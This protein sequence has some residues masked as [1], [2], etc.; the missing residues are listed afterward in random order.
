MPTTNSAYGSGAGKNN[1]CDESSKLNPISNYAKEKVRLEKIL[2]NR[3][4]SVSFRLA[5]VFGASP[6]M[7][8]DLL[9]NDFVYKAYKKIIR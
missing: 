7:R 3:E 5:T 1:Y 9:V 6:R 2:M 8:V 4:N